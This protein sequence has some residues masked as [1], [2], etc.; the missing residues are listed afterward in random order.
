MVGVSVQVSI[1]DVFFL[2]FK[3]LSLDY[4]YMIQAICKNFDEHMGYLEIFK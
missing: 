4:I 3:V 2:C 1:L